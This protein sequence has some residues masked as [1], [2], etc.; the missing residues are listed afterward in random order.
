MQLTPSFDWIHDIGTTIIGYAKLFIDGNLIEELKGDY[1]TAY[2]RMMYSDAKREIINE[3]TGNTPEM[4]NPFNNVENEYP[5][6]TSS[7]DS[8]YYNTIP[9]IKEKTSVI[10]LPLV[11]KKPRNRIATSIADR[12]VR[13]EIGIKAC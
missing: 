9:T 13:I 6:H 12:D 1:I 5:Y 11:Y 10:P 4:Y 7:E 3:M 8:K 2:F